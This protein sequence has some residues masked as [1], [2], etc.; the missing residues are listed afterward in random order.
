MPMTE[1]EQR[2]LDRIA[3]V[4]EKFLYGKILENAGY[5]AEGLKLVWLEGDSGVNRT[6]E[7]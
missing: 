4:F 2:E 5:T 7:K 6:G 1:K 3:Y